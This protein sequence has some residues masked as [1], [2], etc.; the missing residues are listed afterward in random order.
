MQSSFTSETETLA[1]VEKGVLTEINGVSNKSIV[2]K[3][4][5][6]PS[7]FKGTMYFAASHNSKS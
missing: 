3:E 6:T 1:V 4:D 7:I 5:V 2:V